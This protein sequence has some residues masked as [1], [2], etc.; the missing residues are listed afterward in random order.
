MKSLLKERVR[1]VYF[2]VF[3]YT[4]HI[5]VTSDVVGSRRNRS[6]ILGPFEGTATAIHSYAG[7]E[8]FIFITKD[9]TPG[10]VAHEA[11]HCVYAIMKWAGALI[12]NETVAYHLDHLVDEIHS[13]LKP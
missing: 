2:P 3:T 11:W 8:S 6:S 13:F 12:D 5:I 4:A 9:A 10:T 1:K 7:R